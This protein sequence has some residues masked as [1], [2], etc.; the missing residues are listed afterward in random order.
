MGKFEKLDVYPCLWDVCDWTIFVVSKWNK[1]KNSNFT[2]NSDALKNFHSFTYKSE[3]NIYLFQY[4]TCKLP[5]VGRMGNVN[6]CLKNYSKDSKSENSISVCKYFSEPK[7]NVQNTLKLLSPNKLGK[8]WQLRRLLKTQ[9]NF[10]ILLR[11]K[12]LYQDG[13]NQELN[14]IDGFF[15]SS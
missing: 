1:Q 3:N 14:N 6:I 10:W 15:C 2:E 9:E 4:R 8:K 12:T 11:L 13:L 5:T 7:N